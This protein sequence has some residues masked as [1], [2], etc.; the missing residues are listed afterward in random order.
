MTIKEKEG[1]GVHKH[2]QQCT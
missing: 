1:A 2:S